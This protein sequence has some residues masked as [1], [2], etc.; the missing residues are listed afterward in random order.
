MRFP[1][2]CLP[3]R[4]VVHMPPSELAI[5]VEDAIKDASE[6]GED[7][8]DPVSARIAEGDRVA[9]GIGVAV[10]SL[11]PAT[12]RADH[13]AGQEA[14]GERIEVTGTEVGGTGGCVLLLACPA[15]AAG[16]A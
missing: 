7:L 5:A 9:V 15:E 14:G 16:G 13:V 10:E 6:R 12:V 4:V 8:R 2:Q 3:E 11:G 1:G